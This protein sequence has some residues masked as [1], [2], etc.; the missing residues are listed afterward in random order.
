MKRRDFLRNT[1]LIGAGTSLGI[2]AIALSSCAGDKAKIYTPEELG[3]FSFAKEAPDGK[4]L[5]AALIGCGGRG[6]GGALEFLAAG[7]NLSI[8]ALADVFPDRIDSCRK[9]L[10]ERRNN[11]VA[12]A[13]CFT[14]FDAF[15]KVLAMKEIDVVLLCTPQ[16]FRP[17]HFKA[18]VEAGKHI[19]M[20]KPGAVD[21][22]GV[23]TLLAAAKA[24]TAKGLTVVTGTCSRH[25]RD[26]WEAY[27]QVKNGI[28]GELISAT[29]HGHQGAMWF[30]NRRPE[31]SDMEYCLRNWFNIN[32]LSG[33]LFTDQT[34]H[35]IDVATWF[36]GQHPVKAIGVGG[37]ARRLIGDTYDY[38]SVDYHYGDSKR[39]FATGKQ[40]DGCD[41]NFSVQILGAKGIVNFLW[42][43]N[44]QI[45][46]YKGNTL[47]KYDYENSPLKNPYEQEHV[48]FVESIRLNKQ[49]NQAEDLAYSTLITIMGRVAAYTG[50][51][52]KWDE[53]IASDLRYGPTEYK[54]GPL[55]DYHEGVVPIQGKEPKAMG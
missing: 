37:R 16:H 21:P 5:K 2:P 45:T 54:L 4:P 41:G 51:V 11:E 43:N 19:F 50:K 36:M 30:K 10:K 12:D 32:W 34:V 25:R 20:E 27:V 53:I 39:L 23:R 42:N 48:H 9:I 15:K 38:L 24:A 46:D 3:M 52:I 14:G 29:A 31:W 44:V 18:A 6:T 26:T 40:I 17:E 47:W 49:V 22:I 7:P 28:I 8:V 35:F 13:N 33:G 1:A 55:P